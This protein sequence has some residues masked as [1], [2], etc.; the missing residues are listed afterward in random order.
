[1]EADMSRSAYRKAN[2]ARVAWV[3]AWRHIK[4]SLRNRSTYVMAAFY[5]LLPFGLVLFT[6][7][8]LLRD[9]AASPEA[10]RQIGGVIALYMLMAGLLPSTWSVGIAAGAFAAEKEQGSLVP[11]LATPASNASIFAGK[12]LGAVLP[13][14]T[15]AAIGVL[16]YLAENALLF[17]P[18]TLALLPPGITVL[19]LALLP[20]VSLLGAG[21]SSMISAR[22]NTEQ[23]A[24]QY[25][26]I[27]LTLLWVF[28][29]VVVLRVAAWGIWPFAAAVA[30]VFVVSIVLVVVSAATWRR[31][32]VMARR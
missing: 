17:G 29:F 16:G 10:A 32:E 21:L 3:I 28:L 26:S 4:E 27:I 30:A 24:N 18:R 5:V 23:I 19:I 31:E 6:V 1:M 11:L 2:P 9:A 8:P 20:A 15:L 7:R 14:L 12:V 22:V 25:G 13:A